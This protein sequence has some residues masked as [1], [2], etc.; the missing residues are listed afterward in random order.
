MEVEVAGR[1]DRV[2]ASVGA[3]AEVLAAAG[4]GRGDEDRLVVLEHGEHLR[5]EIDLDPIRLRPW[6]SAAENLKCVEAGF[7]RRRDPAVAGQPEELVGRG[8]RVVGVLAVLAVD[9]CRDRSAVAS[10]GFCTASTTGPLLP[11]LKPVGRS[12]GEQRRLGLVDRAA[13]WCS[14]SGRAS[15]SSARWSPVVGA[16]PAARLP[17]PDDEE[18]SL[19]LDDRDDHAAGGAGRTTTTAISDD[20][21]TRRALRAAANVGA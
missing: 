19:R 12:R 5:V 11:Q 16:C 20:A 8:D 1:G 2:L 21:P 3:T 14:S 17:V 15:W 4:G 13:S 10:A 6:A 9:A 7:D 18:P